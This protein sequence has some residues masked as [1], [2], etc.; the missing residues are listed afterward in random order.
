[1]R[2]DGLEPLVLGVVD[3]EGEHADAGLN[4]LRGLRDL[5]ELA[6]E[7]RGTESAVLVDLREDAA[8]VGLVQRGN[9]CPDRS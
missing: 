9:G 2:R 7:I 5:V 3:P 1:M 4:R 8:D 6:G